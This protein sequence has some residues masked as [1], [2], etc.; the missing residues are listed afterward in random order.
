MIQVNGEKAVAIVKEEQVYNVTAYASAQNK[1]LTTTEQLIEHYEQWQAELQALS[2]AQLQPYAVKEGT[3]TYL[4]VVEKP[5]KVICVGLN[6]KKHA[7]E[8]NMPIPTKP[9]LFNKFANS[10]AAHGEEIPAVFDST[11]N[12][13]EAELAI[14]IGKEAKNVSKEEALHYVFGY[15]NAN[16]LSAR[17]LQFRTNQWL[18]GKAI[19]K[20]LPIGPYLVTADEVGNP[21][22]LTI[23]TIYNGEL[24]QNSNTAD[25]IFYCDEIIAYLS[26]YLTL[27]PSDIIITGTPEGVLMGL[28][29][30]ERHFMKPGDEMIIQ[31]E[32][33][34]QLKNVL[35]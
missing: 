31:I 26:Q 9:V 33:L 2:A 10:L 23:Q 6:Y 11:Q 16:D 29:E 20:Y 28:P 8:S 13:Y 19:D 18:L 12:D 35:V 1:A 5:E 15:A 27:K 25:M 7:I 3:F 17:D 4:P 21:N 24:V 30:E 22:H 32:K 14:I 34:G